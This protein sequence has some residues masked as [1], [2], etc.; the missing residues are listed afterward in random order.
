MQVGGAKGG[1][2]RGFL[3]HHHEQ[4]HNEREGD[5][6]A[7]ERPGLIEQGRPGQREARTQVHRVANQSIR[8]DDDQTP[9]RVK[10]RGRPAADHD[11]GDDAPQGQD[12]TARANCY[13]GDLRRADAGGPDDPG[14]RENT[15]RQEHQQETDKEGGVGDRTNENER[16]SPRKLELETRSAGPVQGCPRCTT[17]VDE[18]GEK[19]PR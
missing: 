12:G 5:T 4:V 17:E 13:A 19:L 15:G 6:V 11:E 7:K 9:R 1:A 14:P 16:G 18:Q 8:A 2:Q 10:R 3:M